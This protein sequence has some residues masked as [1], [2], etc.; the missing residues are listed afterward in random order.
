MPPYD[1]PVQLNL[2]THFLDARLDE[3]HGGRV[4]IRTDTETL[5]YAD[6]VALS[7]RCAHVLADAGVRPEERVIIALPDGPLFVGALFGVLRA[8][9]VVVMVNPEL[10]PD[11]LRYFFEYSR[12][13]VAFIDAARASVFDEATRGVRGT[14]DFGPRTSDFG[15]RT[16]DFGPRT[17]DVIFLP[18]GDPIFDARLAAYPST[19]APFPSHRDDP[20]VW[21]FSG[22]TT[23][24]P[25]AV[26]QTNRSFANAA[27]MYG[28][29]V[30]D[31]RPDDITIAVPK[32]FFGYATGANVLFPFLVGA[33][34]VLFPERSTAPT[35]F[36]QIAR[37]RPTV[38]VNVPSMVQ[39]MV[40]HP[41]AASQDL[42]CL[43]FATSAGEALPVELHER[44]TRTFGVDLLD[45]LGTAEMWHIFISNRPGRCVPGTLGWVVPGYE[46]KLC[47]EHGRE[48][49]DGETGALFVKGQSRGICYFERMDETMRTFR[50]EWTVTG[51][52]LRRNPD[53][54]FVYCGRADEMAK[55]SGRWLVP[56]EVE[57]CLL[58]HAAVREVAVVP[59]KNADGLVKPIA[60]VVANRPSAAL[61]SEL[62]DLVRTRL[63]RFKCPREIVF[64]QELPR[65]HLNK[66]DRSALARS[67]ATGL[68]TGG[69]TG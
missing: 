44:W 23:G 50:G 13:R 30:L 60:F 4:A 33:S 24:H 53:G 28:K 67:A 12:T 68:K 26:V 5:T 14:S 65:T 48:V 20:A 45:G 55:V 25:K 15:P 61:A 21:L 7:A 47:D 37:H 64:L 32:L 42:S 34:T 2:A 54:T 66:I 58:Q 56:A 51:D 57:N 69:P 18:V 63:E 43:R 59:L 38:L 52:L 22:G 3:G 1:P 35:L 8:G 36:E 41:D 11:A 62:L 46:V 31:L 17:S 19:C 29:G 10:P 40:A 6:I 39:Q 9:A 16:S 27:Q 49:P